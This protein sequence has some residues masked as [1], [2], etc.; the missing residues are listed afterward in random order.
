MKKQYIT[1]I[2]LPGS[3]VDSVFVVDN[4]DIKDSKIQ[5]GNRFILLGLHDKTGSIKGVFFNPPS[6]IIDDLKEGDIV[7]VKGFTSDSKYG[8]QINISQIDILSETEYDIEDFLER[9]P[10]SVQEMVS[11]TE[12]YINSIK[13]PE[14]Q[15][16]LK[17]W[18]SDSSF[19]KEYFTATAAKTIHHAYIG[20]LAEHSLETLKIALFLS[21]LKKEVNRDIIIAGSLLHDIGKIKDYKLSTRIEITDDGKLF[22]HIILGFTM[23]NERLLVYEMNKRPWAKHLCHII[24][25]HHGELDEHSPV[26]PSTME[27]AIIHYSDLISG[28]LDQFKR[29]LLTTDTNNSEWTENDRY[30]GRALYKG[31]INRT[32]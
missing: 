2:L 23:L 25:S 19:K 5:N 20:G 10:R 11:E 15:R 7:Y 3:N 12:S 21:E 28:R 30:L 8:Y 6:N 31:F 29:V 4:L 16:F 14:I 27:S 26:L 18:F 13:D 9:S 1:D 17:E 22:N 24:L 32:E